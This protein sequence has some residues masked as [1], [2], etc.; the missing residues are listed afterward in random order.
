MLS[1]GCNPGGAASSRG[2][3]TMCAKGSASV[4]MY[5]DSVSEIAEHR[6]S[7]A[8]ERAVDF[9]PPAQADA[10]IS[11]PRQ[12]TRPGALIGYLKERVLADAFLRRL[13]FPR[14]GSRSGRWTP[15]RSLP[16]HHQLFHPALDTLDLV[17]VERIFF[18]VYRTRGN[19]PTL[20]DDRLQKTLPGPRLHTLTDCTYH[21]PVGEVGGTIV[22]LH[23][24]PDQIS[25]LFRQK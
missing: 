24:E 18:V 20:G 13:R 8:G 2:L 15:L 4:E 6:S 17:F 23:F 1:P 12:V 22:D 14:F 5:L 25:A 7:C 19:S 21:Q 9:G 3:P 16:L 11:R 10:A